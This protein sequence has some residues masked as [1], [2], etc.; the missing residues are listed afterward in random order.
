MGCSRIAGLFLPNVA[1]R[2][3]PPSICE[4]R[5]SISTVLNVKR[6]YALRL[7]CSGCGHFLYGD[8][9]RYR[10]PAPTCEQFRAAIPM[11]RRQ[12][13]NLHDTRIRGH[14]YPQSW[15]EDAVAALL[16][17]IGRV[18]NRRSARWFASTAITARG[19]TS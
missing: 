1:S 14:S 2:C 16:A 5:S 12:R 13:Q 7:R 19:P 6:Q 15:Y 18:D 4:R 17:Q 3:T 11:V 10:H 8:T 9:G